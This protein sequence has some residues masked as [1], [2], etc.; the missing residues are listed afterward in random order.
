[1]ELP[2]LDVPPS[3]IRATIDFIEYLSRGAPDFLGVAIL[4]IGNPSAIILNSTDNDV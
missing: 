4:G 2:T 3:M 1:V